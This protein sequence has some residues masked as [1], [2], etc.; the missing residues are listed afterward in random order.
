MI[1]LIIWWYLKYK[2]DADVINKYKNLSESNAPLETPY[3]IHHPA[4]VNT[5]MTTPSM[6]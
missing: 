2:I 4:T 3:E 1:S 5:A 6:K